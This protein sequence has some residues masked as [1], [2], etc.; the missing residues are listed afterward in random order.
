MI[1]DDAPAP[2]PD[3]DLPDEG[4]PEPGVPDNAADARRLKRQKRRN[5]LDAAEDARFW[6]EIFASPVG[7][8]NMWR[9]LAQAGLLEANFGN[10]PVGFPDP[11]ATFFRL[12]VKSVADHLLRE[13]QIADHEGVYM[14]LLEHHPRYPKPD[15]KGAR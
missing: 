3:D 13:W 10:S 7:R 11:H 9:I 4:E 5:E 1:D 8:R 2:E 14:M 15:K 12:G 6:T